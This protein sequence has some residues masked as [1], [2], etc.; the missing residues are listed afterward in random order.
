MKKLAE[1]FWNEPAFCLGVLGTLAMIA[2]KVA[3]QS[4]SIHGVDDLAQILTP[5]VTGLLTRRF[6]SPSFKGEPN[7]MY[8]PKGE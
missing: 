8:P 1:K 3:S 2:L 4:G 7:T 6:V 5:L